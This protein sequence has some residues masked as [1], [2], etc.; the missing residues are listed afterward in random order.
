MCG[1]VGEISLSGAVERA[2]L[3]RMAAA[4]RHRGPDEEGAHVSG[5]GRWGVAHRR[6]CILDRAGGRQPFTAPGTDCSLVYNG[7]VYDE[8]RLRGDLRSRG[9]EFRTRS[10]TEV[11]LALHAL[12]GHGFLAHLRGEFA[13][14]LFDE[15]RRQVLLVRDRLGLKPLYWTRLPGRLLFASE[16]K[17]LFRDPR[18][19][20][21]WDPV[22]LCGALA[23]AETPGRTVFKGIRQV[24]NA[25]CMTV[26]LDTLEAREERYWD[27]YAARRRDV[28]ADFPAQREAIRAAVDE[29][30]DLRLR[31]DVPVGTYLSGGIDSSIVTARVAGRLGGVDAFAISYRESPR[32]D[33]WQHAQAL[34]AAHPAIRLREIPLDGVSVLAAMPATAWHLEKPFGNAH[35][36]AKLLAARAVSGKVGCLLTGDGGDEVFCGYSTFWLQRALEGAGYRLAD[37][38][39]AL[40]ERRREEARIGGNLYYLK[41]ITARRLR[42]TSFL[43]ARLGFRPVELVAAAHRFRWLKLL[44][45]RDFRARID[46][47]PVEVL[48]RTAGPWMPRE[49]GLPHDLLLQHLHLVAL[50]P[51]YVATLADRTE[52]AGSVEARPPLFDHR[53]I[54]LAMGLPMESKLKGD[55]EKHV[56]REAFADVLPP[57]LKERRKQGFLLPPAPFSSKAG[58]A[59]V[60]EYLS[61][62]AVRAAGVFRPSAVRAAR[63]LRS[64]VLLTAMLT[65]QIVHRHL[66]EEPSAGAPG[67][68]DEAQLRHGAPAEGS[69]IRWRWTICVVSIA[70]R[71]TLERRARA[72]R[73][74]EGRK[75]PA[76]R[77]AAGERYSPTSARPAFEEKGAGGRRTPASAAP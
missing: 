25:H 52:Y 14:A 17:A 30:V 57:A 54:E 13:F 33:E 43:D 15:R 48:A 65:T 10:D 49:K 4:L 9:W 69:S 55:R 61:P 42:R 76:A 44:L 1:F 6:L 51:E 11:V 45:S 46:A 63:A 39:R 21:E 5:D 59:L 73:T 7:E 3:E 74:A 38:R 24:P 27:P 19:T 20:R 32:H 75:T 68:V 77:T 70:V 64:S 71:R 72:A 31:S 56:L 58:R 16:A 26:D 41:G 22:G 67:Q 18:V 29:A 34:A 28:P 23:V 2:A 37:L 47:S 60:G 50:A 8:P 62:A 35:A 53:L 36:V 40:R 66:I 12:H